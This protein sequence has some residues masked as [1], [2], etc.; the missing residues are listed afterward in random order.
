MNNNTSFWG[1]QP[2]V[3]LNKNEMLELW[4]TPNMSY[5][6]KLNAITRLIILLT[7]SKINNLQKL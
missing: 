2:E 5:E 3:L 6:S 7:F 4:P 1:N